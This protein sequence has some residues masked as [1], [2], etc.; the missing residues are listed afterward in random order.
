MHLL[1]QIHREA[2]RL[3][4]YCH[5]VRAGIQKGART[6]LLQALPDCSET[7]E[8]ARRLYSRLQ[9]HLATSATHAPR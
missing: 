9:Q 4:R 3:E 5:R 8:I 2:I 6:D 7:G 1:Q